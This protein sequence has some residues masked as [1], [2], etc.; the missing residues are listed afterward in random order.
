MEVIA[1]QASDR[2][3]A[4]GGGGAST[5]TSGAATGCLQIC[6]GQVADWNSELGSA[7]QSQASLQFV[8]SGFKKRKRQKKKGGNEKAD[9]ETGCSR[10]VREDERTD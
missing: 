5:C 4:Q 9:I 3:V 6:R 7:G 2:G 1:H 8:C 10:F